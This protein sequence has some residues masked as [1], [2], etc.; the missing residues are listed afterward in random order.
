MGSVWCDTQANRHNNTKHTHNSVG[1]RFTDTHTHAHTGSAN[2]CALVLFHLFC[3]RHAYMDMVSKFF[4]CVRVCESMDA[5]SGG[6][7]VQC[8][9][10]LEERASSTM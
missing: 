9:K 5:Y 3:M 8:L 10:G 1:T 4:L 6:Q 7:N 2:L